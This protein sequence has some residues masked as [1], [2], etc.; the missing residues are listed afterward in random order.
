[1]MKQVFQE[2]FFILAK[3]LELQDKMLYIDTACN[4]S[5]VESS[6]H[7]NFLEKRNSATIN[8]IFYNFVTNK[9]ECINELAKSNGN[10]L[11]IQ[12]IILLIYQ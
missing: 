4:V 9:L 7:I 2:Q 1:M 3:S 8:P 6:Q 10:D 12:K 5:F 11:I